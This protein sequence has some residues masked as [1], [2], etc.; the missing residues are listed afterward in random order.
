MEKKKGGLF[1]KIIK[2]FLVLTVLFVGCSIIF[3]DDGDYSDGTE[4]AGSSNAESK[5]AEDDEE[6]GEGTATVL[7]YIIGSDLESQGGCATQDIQEICNA[8]LGDNVNVVIQ[9]GGSTYWASPYIDANTVERFIVED[10]SLTMLDDLGRKSMV[11]AN[12]L[13]DF[14]A[15]GMDNYPADTTGVILW[16]HGGGTI[17]GYGSDELYPDSMMGLDEMSK[18]FQKAGKHFD[19]V[20]FDACLMSTIETAYTLEPYADYLIASEETEPGTGW[21][22]TNWLSALAKNPTAKITTIGSNIIKDFVNGPDTS[23]WDSNTLAVVDLSKIPELYDRLCDYLENARGELQYGGYQKIS[24]ARSNAKAYG[25]GEFEQIDIVDYLS[26]A[27]LEGSEELREAVQ[28]A[29]VCFDANIGRSYGLAMYFPY[30]SPN[31]YQQVS[32][33]LDTA[34]FSNSS[35]KGFFNDYLSIMVNGRTTRSVSSPIAAMSGYSEEVTE[36]DLTDEDWYDSDV[37]DVEAVDYNLTEDGELF[38]DEKGDGFVLHMT[39]EQWDTISSISMSVF[40]DDG[41][42]YIDLGKDDVYSFDDDGDMIADFNYYWLSLN[43]QFAPYYVEEQGEK[44]N[45]DW[46]SRGYVPAELTKKSDGSVW[47]IEIEMYFD[48]D[49]ASGAVEGYRIVTESDDGPSVYQ[50]NLM[51]FEDG[52]EIAFVCDYYTYDGE[53]DAQYYFGDPIVVAGELE[54]TYEEI[55]EMATWIYFTLT[56]IYQNDWYTESLDLSFSQN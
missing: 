12:T 49:H 41:E 10:G 2:I 18:A 21:Y 50:R 56:D 35:Y 8:N 6:Y 7:L 53:Y 11:D 16:D 19:F 52:D 17:C 32:R 42:G 14:L 13:G 24:Y 23:F 46:Y 33:Q 39:D 45:G 9:T 51:Q 1:G 3:S 47:D 38:L 54:A 15:W 4:T 34:G 48:D 29:V 20:G 27:D 31:Y 43:G 22:Y 26:Y 25:D 5:Y 44:D 30:E 28:D 36:T 55:D 37:A 40:L